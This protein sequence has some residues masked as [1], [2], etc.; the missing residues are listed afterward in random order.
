MINHTL[1]GCS[2]LSKEDPVFLL[3]PNRQPAA[4]IQAQLTVVRG[5]QVGQVY[6]LEVGNTRF[7]RVEGQMLKDVMVSRCHM[8]I[9]HQGDKAVVSDLQSTN[10]TYV[11]GQR[12]A[13]PVPLHHGDFIRIGETILAFEIAGKQPVIRVQGSVSQRFADH[14]GK[15][16]TISTSRFTASLKDRLVERKT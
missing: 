8:Q 4:S 9:T 16:A 12:I 7:G 5:S 1:N 15:E 6:C 13:Q 3:K 10:G 14:S 2:V 11:N